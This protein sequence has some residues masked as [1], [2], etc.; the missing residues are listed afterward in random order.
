[1]AISSKGV[2]ENVMKASLKVRFKVPIVKY[3]AI[4]LTIFKE[5]SIT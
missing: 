4:V 2:R 1:M 3:E 5:G